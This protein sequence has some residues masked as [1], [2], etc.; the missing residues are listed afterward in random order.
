MW[1][2]ICGEFEAETAPVGPHWRETLSGRISIFCVNFE[3]WDMVL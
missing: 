2:S 1:E 3:T